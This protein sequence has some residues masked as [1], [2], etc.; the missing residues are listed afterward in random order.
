MKIKLL[1]LL[2]ASI[3]LFQ[4][5]EIFE[6]RDSELPDRSRFNY[7]PATDI[8]ILFTNFSNSMLEK[9]IQN[10]SNLFPQASFSTQKLEFTPAISSLSRFPQ[11]GENWSNDDEEKYFRNVTN[12]IPAED[13]IILELS[14][15]NI[16]NFG[17]SIIV[18]AKY[19]LNVAHTESSIP[20][21][22]AG[23]F[24]I[25]CIRDVRQI[26]SI[27]RWKDLSNGTDPCWSDLKGYFY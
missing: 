18:T 4:S 6:V 17:D 22:F 7:L 10:Y 19:R 26:L 3:F 5:C 20:V 13:G 25:R 14:D 8:D 15:K 9:S 16:V 1:L 11:L 23:E 2:T 12:K 27:F 21:Y 24:E